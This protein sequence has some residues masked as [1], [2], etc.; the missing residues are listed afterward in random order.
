MTYLQGS[1]HS[2]YLGGSL[3]DESFDYVFSSLVLL[4]MRGWEQ[5]IQGASRLLR[6]GGWMEVQETSATVWRHDPER[7]LLDQDV[8]APWKLLKEVKQ[9]AAREGF[10]FDVVDKVEGMMTYAGMM[11]VEAVGLYEMP[12]GTWGEEHTWEMGRYMVQWLKMIYGLVMEG[13]LHRR[14]DLDLEMTRRLRRE[15]DLYLGEE[16]G[17]YMALNVVTG[18]KRDRRGFY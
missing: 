1:F 4:K 10:D 17:K 7:P 8:T 15:L 6:P 11:D 3:E 5:F 14:G 2:L 16:V 18:W 13:I 9:E 12:I